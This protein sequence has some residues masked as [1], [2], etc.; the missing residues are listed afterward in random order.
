[1]RRLPAPSQAAAAC[2]SD[3]GVL[4]PDRPASLVGVLEERVE[5]A[6]EDE[7]KSIGPVDGGEQLAMRSASVDSAGWLVPDAPAG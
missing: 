6:S 4:R 1:M 5:I 2:T 7:E 3:R